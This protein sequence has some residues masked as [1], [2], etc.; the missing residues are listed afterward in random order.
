MS[1]ERDSVVR[2]L[3]KGGSIIFV[4]LVVEL[5]ISFAA[6]VLMAR[7]LGK[8]DY[9]V[10]TIGITVLAF[11]STVF[12]LGLNTGVGRYLPRYDDTGRRKGVIRSAV[13]VV[14]AVSIAVAALLFVFAE[15][16]ATHALGAP[17]ASDVLRIA[18][19]GL[20]FAAMLKLSI[21]VVQ[22][23][24]QSLPKVV[25]RNVSQPVLRFALVAAAL[26]IGAGSVGIVWAYVIAFAL[27]AL[28]G[29][30]YVVRETPAL[31]PVDAVPMRRELVAFSAPLMLMTSMLMVLSKLDIFLVSYFRE[32][33]A[34][35]TYN[36]V[37]PL[38]ELMTVTLS[39]FSFIFMPA[40]S[41]L[42]ADGKDAEM[43]RIYQVVTKWIF[44]VTLPLFLG[45]VLF[46]ET[47]IGLT[48]GPEYAD[49]SLALVVLALGFFTHGV[50]GPNVNT[51]TSIGRTRIIM[52]DNL[53][54]AA[55]NVALNVLLIPRY[56]F[57]GAAVA[58][59]VSYAGLNVLYSVQLYRATGIHP[60]TGEILRPGALAVVTMGALYWGMTTA[61]PVTPATVV[62][63]MV[64][65]TAI[66]GVI[67]VRFG[68]REEEVM[69][70]LS[71]EER[72]GVDLG[73][74]KTVARRLR[75]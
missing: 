28:L 47:A 2:G 72:F 49:G 60:V 44:V 65:F 4:G 33:A 45:M 15:P 74:V 19:L 43:H 73:P 31:A 18:A 75:G 50:A 36:V 5:G 12:L 42:H 11:G 10:A 1:D 59:T 26:V 21:G 13:Q 25:I 32:T 37:Y 30:Y 57:L 29:A 48:F 58:T 39:A 41:E 51:L 27:T 23:M 35:A 66:Y 7:V 53:L 68:V 62:G 54:A 20:P 69:L 61:V 38:S 24:Q 40:L 56:S 71:F 6:K 8:F 64:A 52:I 67:V 63:T 16:I 22:G 3:F 34:V 46:P 70:L 9:G 17:E 14:L 55:A